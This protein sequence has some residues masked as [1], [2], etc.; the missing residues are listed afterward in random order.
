MT[1]TPHHVGQ[2]TKAEIL[3]AHLL[4]TTPADTTT[5]RQAA[6]I[7]QQLQQ[8]GWTPPRDPAADVP[9]LRPDRIADVDSPGRRAFNEARKALAN[10]PRSNP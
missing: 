10:R 8:A 3:V 6:V 4:D 9:P 7:V 5:E 2:V 1:A